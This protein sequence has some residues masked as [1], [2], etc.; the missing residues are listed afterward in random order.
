MH[1]PRHTSEDHLTK[2]FLQRF[3]A[4]FKKKKQCMLLKSIRERERDFDKLMSIRWTPS[5][6]WIYPL[7]ASYRIPILGC[8]FENQYWASPCTWLPCFW[9]IILYRPFH[10]KE[11]RPVSWRFS[12]FDEFQSFMFFFPG[13]PFQCMA[14]CPMRCYKEIQRLKASQ[15]CQKRFRTNLSYFICTLV[16]AFPQ[17]Y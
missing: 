6:A 10:L 14:V 9:K 13:C 8:N 5:I 12:C 11:P 3:P 15:D 1:R 17:I 2:A 16:A 7:M 4:I